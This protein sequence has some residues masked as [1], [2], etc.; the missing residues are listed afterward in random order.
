MTQ[1]VSMIVM[2]VPAIVPATVPMILPM[3]APM[4][5]PATVP[6]TAPD[7]IKK[8]RTSFSDIRSSKLKAA[9]TYSPTWWGSTIGASELN[10]SVRYGKRWGLTA[11]ATAVCFWKQIIRSDVSLF[12]AMHLLIVRYPPIYCSKNTGSTRSYRDISTG[13]LC[14]H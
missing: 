7:R 3:T 4:I 11:I 1:I 2:I 13:R 5:L 10:F 6:M 9:A 12:I 8:D 14:H